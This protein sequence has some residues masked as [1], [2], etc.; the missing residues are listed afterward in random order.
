MTHEIVVASGKGGTGKTFVASNLSFYLSSYKNVSLV[1]VDAD[2]E[3]PDLLIALGGLRRKLWEY[4]F[5]GANEPVINTER[6]TACWKCVELCAFGAIV[7]GDST[8]VIDYDKCEGLGVCAKLCPARAIVLRPRRTGLLYAAESSQGILVV[9]GELELGGRNSGRLV[10]EL[11]S[12]ARAMRPEFVVVDSAP[13]IGC[14]VVS[15]VS[16]ADLLVI[17][18]EPVPQSLRGAQRLIS[19]AEQLRTDWVVIL[20]KY[21][22][23]T[24][25]ADRIATE[26]GDRLVG[27]VP[28]DDSVV[29]S[30][31]SMV[32]ILKYRPNSPAAVA[33][34]KALERLG[35]DYGWW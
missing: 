31:A 23:N 6:C 28:Y 33:L 22:I 8:P 25:L 27:T 5:F 11:K 32:P 18:V 29:E 7:K 17:V 26:L 1:A 24:A 16:G 4:E 10:Y 9:T 35:G 2:V 19:V 15:S 12:R 30:Y 20:N 3:A 14:P 13:G 34:S 21:D